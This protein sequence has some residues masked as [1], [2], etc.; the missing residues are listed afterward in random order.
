M[1]KYFNII[2]IICLITFIPNV[3]AEEG[4]GINLTDVGSTSENVVV[5]DVNS[6]N[7]EEYAVK[8]EAL[9]KYLETEVFGKQKLNAEQVTQL[10]NSLA[11]R[12]FKVSDV[13]ALKSTQ[14]AEIDKYVKLDEKTQQSTQTVSEIRKGMLSSNEEEIKKEQEAILKQ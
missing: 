5:G 4:N 3:Y 14:L 7:S 8:R 9:N 2:I 10:R 12:L 11:K 1:K 13:S 6:K